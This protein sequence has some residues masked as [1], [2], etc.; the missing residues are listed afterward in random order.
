MITK[1]LCSADAGTVAQVHSHGCAAAY[2]HVPS[3]T[4]TDYS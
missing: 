1:G 4:D 2:V 3:V